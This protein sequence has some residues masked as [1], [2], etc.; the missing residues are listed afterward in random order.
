LHNVAACDIAL[1][2]KT[3]DSSSS[4]EVFCRWHYG[5]CVLGESGCPAGGWHAQ[6]CLWPGPSCDKWFTTMVY[7][8]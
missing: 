4:E 1:S 6:K 3:K 8:A 2:S 7:S 5:I